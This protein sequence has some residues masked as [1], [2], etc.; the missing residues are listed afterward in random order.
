VWWARG[1][2]VVRYGVGYLNTAAGGRDRLSVHQHL[3]SVVP[4]E[5][6]ILLRR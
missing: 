6:L 1:R 3:S 2:E 4:E 5:V